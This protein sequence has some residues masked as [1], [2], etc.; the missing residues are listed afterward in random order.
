[1]TW[2]RTDILAERPNGATEPP[3]AKCVRI[4]R[5]S[6]YSK[7]M[8]GIF[9]VV[10]IGGFGLGTVGGLA[11]SVKEFPV[12]LDHL[13]FLKGINVVD[14][15]ALYFTA[16]GGGA[17]VLGIVVQVSRCAA[18]HSGRT[19]LRTPEEEL[20][21]GGLINRPREYGIYRTTR[22]IQ[23]NGQTQ[24][25]A[26]VV[27]V[28]LH[29]KQETLVSKITSPD[30]TEQTVY[31][32]E[33]NLSYRYFRE[34]EHDKGQLIAVCSEIKNLEAEKATFSQALPL[35]ASSQTL[36]NHLE[37]LHKE[38]KKPSKTE[39]RQPTRTEKPVSIV[40]IRW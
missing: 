29:G 7:V 26:C 23:I 16:A 18:N 12:I 9:I 35:A 3:D 32:V 8:D 27:V 6:A 40:N 22:E 28:E 39:P 14:P 38:G 24:K 5:K 33:T 13:P 17:F 21:V 2:T 37:T 19:Y 36:A 1:M 11:L 31:Y 10:I 34:E 30:G 25:I 15:Y 20:K 4:Q